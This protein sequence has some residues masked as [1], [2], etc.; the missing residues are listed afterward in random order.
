[1]REGTAVTG[2]IYSGR[3]RH[4][5]ENKLF[6]DDYPIIHLLPIFPFSFFCHYES[7]GFRLDSKLSTMV[8][9]RTAIKEGRRPCTTLDPQPS[10]VF[11]SKYH[12][13]SFRNE[14]PLSRVKNWRDRFSFPMIE[15]L[16]KCQSIKI[17]NT[18]NRNGV[19]P[20]NW[21]GP[22]EASVRPALEKGYLWCPYWPF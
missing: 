1:M 13:G 20:R 6:K 18:L 2:V 9:T 17:S 14:I 7:K 11:N 3:D 5:P 19:S 22:A 21:E 10:P 4:V 16:P 15:A 12:G 8:D